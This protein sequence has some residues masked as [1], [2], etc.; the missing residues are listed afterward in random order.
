MHLN[1]SRKLLG[2]STDDEN[3]LF[4]ELFLQVRKV[5]TEVEGSPKD[6]TVFSPPPHPMHTVNLIPPT[7][8]IVSVVWGRMPSQ[9]LTN[10]RDSMIRDGELDRQRRVPGFHWSEKVYKNT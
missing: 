4:F 2:F 8:S 3:S 1:I 5:S 6:V 7:S 9:A 10:N